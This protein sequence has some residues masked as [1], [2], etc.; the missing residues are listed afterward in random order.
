M[1]PVTGVLLVFLVAVTKHLA[2]SNLRKGLGLLFVAV[3]NTTIQNN[4]ER[5]GGSR[6][7]LPESQSIK[8]SRGRNSRQELT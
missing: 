4:L 7:L 2:K 3:T 5:E 1:V 8:G 6:L